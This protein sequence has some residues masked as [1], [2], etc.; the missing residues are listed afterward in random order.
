MLSYTYTGY[1]FL[2]NYIYSL[3]GMPSLAEVC[4]DASFKLNYE[5]FL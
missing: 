3:V 4:P 5:L 1:E 2:Y